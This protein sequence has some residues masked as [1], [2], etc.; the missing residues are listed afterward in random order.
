MTFRRPTRIGTLQPGAPSTAGGGVEGTI[1]VSPETLLE[2]HDELK[3]SL[4]KDTDADY[5]GVWRG[6][7][8]GV[9]SGL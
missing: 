3:S 4:R 2:M 5:N 9:A 6:D 7:P 8:G 1:K